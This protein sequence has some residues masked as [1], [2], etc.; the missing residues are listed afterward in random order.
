ML[1]VRCSGGLADRS[2]RPRPI[3]GWVQAEKFCDS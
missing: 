1:Y 2:V 3:D